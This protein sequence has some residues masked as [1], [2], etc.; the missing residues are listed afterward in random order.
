MVPFYDLTGSALTLSL[1]T[2]QKELVQTGLKL[3]SEWRLEGSVYTSET[4]EPIQNAPNLQLKENSFTTSIK[5]LG[6]DKFTSGL[7]AGYL[8]GDYSGSNNYSYLNPSYSQSTA[9]F[10]TNYKSIRTTFE[11]QIG[12]TR[13]VSATGTNNTS[14]LTGVFS[15][16]QQLT[17]K[18][19]FTG[20]I[21]RVI[22]SY[23]LNAGSEI[24]TDAGADL[25][26]QATFKLA[27][28]LGYTF[29][30]QDYPGQ[31]NNPVGSNRVDI[32]EYPTM[33]ISYQP[34][35]WLLI[36]PYANWQTRRSTFIGAHFSANIIGVSRNGDSLH[37]PS[38]HTQVTGFCW[39]EYTESS[40]Y[41]S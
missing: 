10:L 1:V 9:G 19:S 29:M 23:L 28:S 5:Y 6:I 32:Q 27:V 11:G 2:V 34:R 17:P 41:R 22:D 21:D 31:G 15:F 20:K 18:T 12:Y 13:R 25:H 40:R 3:G 39:A 14:G 33:A 8:S 16:T 7:T 24:E 4:D 35:R 37:A 30:Y 38:L 36:S 26:W